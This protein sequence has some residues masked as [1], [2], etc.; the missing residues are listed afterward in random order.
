MHFAPEYN[1][2]TLHEVGIVKSPAKFACIVIKYKG[3]IVLLCLLVTT[4][5]FNQV[6]LN[7]FHDAHNAHQGA[8]KSDKAQ[9]LKHN[10]HCKICGLDTLFHLYYEKLAQFQGAYTINVP[11]AARVQELVSIPVRNSKGRAPPIA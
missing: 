6:G 10:E 7:Y 4:L 5:L 2:L 1:P 3:Y 9:L 11:V 8:V